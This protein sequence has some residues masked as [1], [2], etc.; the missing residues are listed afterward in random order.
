MGMDQYMY[1]IKNGVYELKDKYTFDNDEKMIDKLF[2]PA[3]EF[4]YWR[5]NFAIQHHF[6]TQCSEYVKI[7]S[8][9]IKALIS[10][11]E[12]GFGEFGYEDYLEFRKEYDLDMLKIALGYIEDDFSVYYEA[13]W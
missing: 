10:N 13:D 1:A 11:I 3:T 5:K 8:E 6:Y 9:N 7:S 4:A 2:T 12:E